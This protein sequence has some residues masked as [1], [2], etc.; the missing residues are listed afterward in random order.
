MQ[1]ERFRR[2]KQ[3]QPPPDSLQ[4]KGGGARKRSNSPLRTP[5]PDRIFGKDNESREKTGTCS[6]FSEAHPIFCKDMQIRTHRRIPIYWY[7]D[8]RSPHLL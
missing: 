1:S 8:Y 6:L 5:R 3:R 4:A 7:I 2:V